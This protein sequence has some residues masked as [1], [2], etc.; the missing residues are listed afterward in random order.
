M[1]AGDRVLF[2]QYRRQ[3]LDLRPMLVE[4]I[5]CYALAPCNE[6]F[7]ILRQQCRRRPRRVVV[8]IV[9]GAP[10]A[11]KKPDRDRF[12]GGAC[13]PA[14]CGAKHLM[15]QFYLSQWAGQFDDNSFGHRCRDQLRRDGGQLLE[16]ECCHRHP[17]QNSADR[18]D[19]HL[20]DGPT[21]VAW[22]A[23]HAG[24]RTIR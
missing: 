13:S 16:I 20:V 6:I 2:E 14:L 11:V 15:L 5:A 8:V 3:R 18:P 12:Q 19:R 21:D 22:S 9:P 1:F 4:H 23:A 10:G 17:A 24:T 7:A